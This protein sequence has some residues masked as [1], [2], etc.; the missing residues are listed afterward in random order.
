MSHSIL[1]VWCQDVFLWLL[2]LS[3]QSYGNLR[4]LKKASKSPILRKFT[5]PDIKF[6]KFWFFTARIFNFVNS[7]LVHGILKMQARSVNLVRINEIKNS[8]QENNNSQEILK[9]L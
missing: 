7:K 1:S 4:I 3:W 2:I 9:S 5:T 6:D 8:R